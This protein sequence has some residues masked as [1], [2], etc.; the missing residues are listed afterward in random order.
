MATVEDAELIRLA[1]GE[2]R[3]LFPVLGRVGS[4]TPLVVLLAALPGIYALLVHQGIDEVG[5]RWGLKA[6]ALLQAGGVEQAVSTIN[7]DPL[8]WQNPLGTWLTALAML[9]FGSQLGL[10]LVLVE[11]LS[12]AAL[13]GVSFLLVRS[14][15]G[16]RTA[17]WATLLLGSH[18]PL[19]EQVVNPMPNSLGLCWGLATFA[20]FLRHLEQTSNVV[21]WALLFAGISLGL[22]L[23]SGGPLAL[24]VSAV[25][26]LHVLALRGE[27]V[28]KR[29][30][31]AVVR[32]KV[33]VGWPALKSLGALL[34]TAFAV[35]GWWMLM[36]S[37]QYGVE[38]R[39]GWFTGAAAGQTQDVALGPLLSGEWLANVANRLFELLGLLGGFALLGL[40]RIIR[41][42]LGKDDESRQRSRKSWWPGWAW[43]F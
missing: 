42:S 13:V 32:K 29:R 17:F 43:R 12:H 37:S 38:F 22:C 20:L 30:G 9:L 5:A 16:A 7:A 21:S 35:G 8:R 18:G 26:L 31:E 2:R 27:H 40:W 34:L 1:A 14:L 25:L 28:T 10:S 39:V 24:A 3:E 41:D 36:M 11:Y 15:F 4:L 33:W 6:L 23:L 19:L